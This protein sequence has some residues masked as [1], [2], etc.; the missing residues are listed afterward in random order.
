MVDH[1]TA[2][3]QGRRSRAKEEPGRGWRHGLIVSAQLLLLLLAVAGCSLLPPKSASSHRVGDGAKNMDTYALLCYERGVR[4][5][6]AFRYELARQQFA[7]AA[8]AAASPAV[9]ADAIDGL[10]RAERLIDE[11]R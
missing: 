1:V 4:Y 6:D 10:R 5:M 3:G 9:Y 2:S 7:Y 11:G 8:A